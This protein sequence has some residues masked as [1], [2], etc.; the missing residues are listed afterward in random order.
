[1]RSLDLSSDDFA[2]TPW[3]YPGTR[4]ATSG[5]LLG[6]RYARL[7]GRLDDALLRSNVATVE[8][9][10]WVVAVG[11]NMSPAVMSLKLSRAGVST[12][13]PFLEAAVSG[14]AVGHSAHISRYGYV[15]AAPFSQ[16]GG[17]SPVVIS[18]LDTR[19][20]RA[21]DRTEPNYRRVRLSGPQIGLEVGGG[22]RRDAF[23]IYVSRWGLLKGEGEGPLR[24]T[25]QSEVFAHVRARSQALGRY[26]AEDGLQQLMRRLA[27]DPRQRERL[28]E[29]FAAEG[30]VVASGLACDQ[31]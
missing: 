1:V 8:R 28:S 19:Q 21:L 17:A 22:V 12:V 3:S 27:G 29:S 5:L 7:P 6:D 2:E 25:T 10:A 11:S 4:P 18:L 15:P 20:L 23:W 13:L 16:P 26:A 30:L 9:R 31:R 24:M 14:L